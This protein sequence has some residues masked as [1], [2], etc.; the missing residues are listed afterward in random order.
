MCR[1]HIEQWPIRSVG[2]SYQH[3]YNII[4]GKTKYISFLRQSL[5]PPFYVKCKLIFD[6][7]RKK[8]QFN[9]EMISMK[10]LPMGILVKIVQ[11]T[12]VFIHAAHYELFRSIYKIRFT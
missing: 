7:S 4:T 2:F 9:S 5:L 10:Y 1:L 12:L 8:V 6:N 11:L 3:H